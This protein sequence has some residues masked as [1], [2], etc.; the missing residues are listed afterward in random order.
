MKTT[1][2]TR[3]VPFF[4]IATNDIVSQLLAEYLIKPSGSQ[5]WQE[6]LERYS[7]KIQLVIKEHEAEV[8]PTFPAQEQVAYREAMNHV[9]AQGLNKLT[10]EILYIR[11][12]K[13]DFKTS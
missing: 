4:E 11:G 13:L 7:S 9:Q 8:L 10:S 12:G 5:F 1:D 6:V 3:K 2:M